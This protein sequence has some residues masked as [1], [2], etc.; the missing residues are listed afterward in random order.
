MQCRVIL[1]WKKEVGILLK[2]SHF[3]QK[4]SCNFMI[5]QH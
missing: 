4:F 1:T 3:E 2:H 5:I